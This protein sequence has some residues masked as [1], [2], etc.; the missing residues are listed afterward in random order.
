MSL[1]KLLKKAKKSVKSIS[2]AVTKAAKPVGKALGTVLRAAAPVLAATGVGLPLAAGAAVAGSALKGGSLKKKVKALKRTGI[3]TAGAAAVAGVVG[4][5]AGTGAGSSLLK[6][7]PALVG[8]V[9]GGGAAPTAEDPTGLVSMEGTNSDPSLFEKVLA[10]GGELLSGGEGAAKDLE[11]AAV[12][13]GAPAPAADE[14]APEEVEVDPET[15]EV[16]PKK[17]VSPL[18]LVGGAAVALVIGVSLLGR[19][20]KKAA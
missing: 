17:K 6:S 12:A 16:I 1:K 5:L 14:A 7:A 8:K 11:A 15:G 2:K 18:L 20:K 9:F 10:S 19:G 4:T 13:A 3:Q